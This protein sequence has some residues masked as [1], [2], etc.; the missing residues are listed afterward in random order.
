MRPVSVIKIILNDYFAFLLTVGGPIAIAISAF[1]A[2]F[3]FIPNI[4]NREGKEVNPQFIF[5]MSIVAV[6]LAVLLVFL[7]FLRISRIKNILAHGIHAKAKVL[8]IW[9]FKDR[10]RVEFEYTHNGQKHTTGTAIMKNKQTIAMVPGD[11]IEVAIDPDNA[12]RAFIVPL[13][14]A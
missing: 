12:H 10:G 11:E 8:E 9:F 7:L 4:R 13:Y 3:G 6:V 14:C 5:G 1:T 2:I